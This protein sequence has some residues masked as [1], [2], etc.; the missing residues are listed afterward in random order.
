MHNVV[1]SPIDPEKLIN[2]I[3]E[4][5]TANILNAVRNEQTPTDQPEQLLTIQEAA[6]F[7]SLAVPTMYS[8]LSKGEISVMKRSKRLYFSRTELMEYVKAGR[9]KSNAEIE[10]EAKAYL[11]NTK[12]GLNNGK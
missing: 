2:S 7:L 11:L 8:K 10:A 4:R 12:K 5:V 3:S 6:E 1:L 9:K